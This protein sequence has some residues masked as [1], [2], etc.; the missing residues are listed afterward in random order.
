MCGCSRHPNII[1]W[2][3]EA[4]DRFLLSDFRYSYGWKL[5]PPKNR[6]LKEVNCIYWIP[7]LRRIEFE[8]RGL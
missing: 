7:S 1:P 2:E 8:L 4:L 5:L 3:R 6:W